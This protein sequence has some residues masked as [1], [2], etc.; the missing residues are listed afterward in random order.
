MENYP[1]YIGSINDFLHFILGSNEKPIIFMSRMKINHARNKNI[2]DKMK[3][4]LENRG[5]KAR[6]PNIEHSPEE[7]GTSLFVYCL[8]FFLIFE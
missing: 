6:E 1:G 3:F 5:T 8:I 2:P 7:K 4:V